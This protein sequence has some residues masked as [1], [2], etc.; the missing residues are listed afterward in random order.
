MQPESSK[1]VPT[2]ITNK[3]R[4]FLSRLKGC[5]FNASPL[6]PDCKRD[7][8][9][10]SAVAKVRL[11]LSNDCDILAL[12]MPVAPLKDAVKY[13]LASHRNFEKWLEDWLKSAT[14]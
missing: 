3:D 12:L 6:T 5:A 2:T 8:I 1:Q 9:G 4:V 13:P 11:P 7:A 10:A 14:R